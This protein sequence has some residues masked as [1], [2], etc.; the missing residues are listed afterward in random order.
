MFMIKPSKLLSETLSN[1]QENILSQL[2]VFAIAGIIAWYMLGRSD[3]RDEHYETL[4]E[5]ERENHRDCLKK[6]ELLQK[7]MIVLER[8]QKKK[9]K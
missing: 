9:E 8:N 2:G 7:R 5:E 3:K 6:I 1:Y 4:L